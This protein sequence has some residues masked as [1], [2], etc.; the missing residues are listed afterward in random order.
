VISPILKCDES[1]FD[2]LAALGAD[3]L[4]VRLAIG[5]ILE[6]DEFARREGLLAMCADKTFGMELLV[7]GSDRGA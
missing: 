2:H 5:F 3:I 7:E 4:E 6:G 1:A